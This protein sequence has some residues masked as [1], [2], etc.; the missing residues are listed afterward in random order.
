MLDAQPPCFSAQVSPELLALMRGPMPLQEGTRPPE[1]PKQ[2]TMCS[3]GAA[4]W[5]RM[6]LRRDGR[7][8]VRVEAMELATRQDFTC[9]QLD[10][11]EI[12]V[13]R[14]VSAYLTGSGGVLVHLVMSPP[15]DSPARPVY[16]VFETDSADHLAGA[17]A[18][19]G[20]ELCFTV[21]LQPVV[22]AGRDLLL[23][24]VPAAPGRHV[25]SD[26]LQKDTQE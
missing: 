6:S 22:A 26:D 20:P 17:L 14:R 23:P 11:T 25:S 21:S 13:T 4:R 1:R 16:R 8:P 9:V 12:E 3:S 15:P 18:Q 2:P 19:H 5:A 10:G 7:R 24:I